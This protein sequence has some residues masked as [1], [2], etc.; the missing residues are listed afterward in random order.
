MKRVMIFIIATAFLWLS[1]GIAH[2]DEL[3]FSD[4]FSSGTF[5][6]RWT[7]RGDVS[8]VDERVKSV[9]NGTYIET[10]QS[11][12]ENL[13]IE[14]DIE[15]YG[16]SD[17]TCWDFA[18]EIRDLNESAGIIRFDYGGVDG[19]A[20]G[21]DPDLWCEKCGED[22]SIDGSAI[23][24]GKAIF[25]YQDGT[26]GFSFENDD[27]DIID[28]GSVYAGNYA[29][30]KIRIY[31]AAHS[32]TPRYVDNVKVYSIDDQ[33]L[34]HTP[35]QMHPGLGII[36]FGFEAPYYGW[37]GEYDFA[38]IPFEDDTGWEPAPDPD[39]IAYYQVPSTLCD[40]MDCR[41]GAE[42]T[43]F[44]TFVDVP[45]NY[46]LTEFSITFS[47]I[48]D[49][50]EVTIFNS[51]Y[52]DG[53]V[54]GYLFLGESG[55]IDLTSHV[56]SGE[57][58]RVVVTHTDDCCYHSYLDVAQ[59]AIKGVPNQPPEAICQDVTVPMEPGVCSA[60]ASV[61]DGSFD[62]D[63][64][65]ITLDQEPP[66]PYDLGDTDVTLTVTDGKGA[67]D[68]CDAT[69]TVIDEEAPVISSVTASPNKFWPPNHKMVPVTVT[70]S[71]SDICDPEP[72]CLITEVASN[73][74]VNGLGDGNTAPDWVITGG[75]TVKLRAERS[76]KGNGRIYTITVECADSSGNSSTDTATVTVPH[77]KGK[78]N[79]KNK[80]KKK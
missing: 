15:K 73:E 27:G 17:H 75:L 49:G 79:N 1:Y 43:Y 80:K 3:I 71:V 58:N 16:N 68:T 57:N 78:G 54:I 69:V 60:D 64:D 55:K 67:S 51:D 48:D 28:A 53:E 18:V 62:P 33:G 32:D 10:T 8:V 44:Q 2:S 31:L 36:P 50:V 65:E 41:W 72:V 21:C 20:I 6:T 9:E 29:S 40:T 13:K 25:T 76:G 70:A 77:D 34:P 39:I 26:V 42:F 47:G 61:D 19:V 56:K 24:K 4:D 11:F 74:P 14:L 37:E 66:S 23:N 45:T 30:S 63:G 52:P 35:W 5:G 46:N 12:S 22:V 38:V 7:H 59:I